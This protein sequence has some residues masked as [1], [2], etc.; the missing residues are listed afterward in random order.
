MPR[1]PH[2]TLHL[3]FASVTYILDHGAQRPVSP[4][5]A[6]TSSQPDDP[7]PPQSSWSVCATPRD[8]SPT[9]H[10]D[11]TLA[12]DSQSVSAPEDPLCNFPQGSFRSPS[13]PGSAS[14]SSPPRSPSV[15]LR[16][17]SPDWSSDSS[18]EVVS[19]FGRSQSPEPFT[20][21]RYNHRRH[22]EECRWAKNEDRTPSKPSDDVSTNQ[23]RLSDHFHWSSTGNLD[24]RSML[25][26][27][28]ER[29]GSR[30]SPPEH[31]HTLQTEDQHD[32]EY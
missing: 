7:R 14:T 2:P 11:S 29:H 18:E 1:P 3:G 20:E 30:S 4:S 13:P 10:P 27:G 25:R 19:P 5:S 6:V 26:I 16:E 23:Y 15:Y 9:S 32:E 31:I 22:S 8:A 28:A 21:A 12:R 17:D 24:A